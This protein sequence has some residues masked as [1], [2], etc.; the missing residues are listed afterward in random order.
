MKKVLRMEH[1][2]SMQRYSEAF[3]KEDGGSGEITNQEASRL[4]IE[5]GLETRG[6]ANSFELGLL[7]AFRQGGAG[8]T[9]EAFCRNCVKRKK[10]RIQEIRQTG[11]FTD[12]KFAKLRELFNSCATKQGQDLV[13]SPARR[14][15][16]AAK[17]SR[18]ASSSR[19]APT[20][21]SCCGISSG[22]RHPSPS[23]SSF[24]TCGT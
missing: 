14:S 23:R 5:L 9:L 6:A 15:A 1:E 16:S 12:N 8:H 22:D 11:S 13:I 19:Y 17:C 7:S 2:A 3:A 21:P 24:D 18:W 4:F 20:S 10:T